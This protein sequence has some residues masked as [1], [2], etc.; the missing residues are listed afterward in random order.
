MV[1]R[2]GAWVGGG[3]LRRVVRSRRRPARHTLSQVSQVH[4]PA[5]RDG[6]GNDPVRWPWTHRSMP[7]PT[8][9]VRAD[10]E[11]KR[12]PSR[13]DDRRDLEI[14]VRFPWRYTKLLRVTH[15]PGRERRDSGWRL[16]CRDNVARG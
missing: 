10:K 5:G 16:V 13:Q 3:C 6:A 11:D 1:V 12:A 8:P 2:D 9:Q 7:A 14:P 4:V 15:A